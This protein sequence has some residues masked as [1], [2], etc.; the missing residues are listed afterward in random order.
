MFLRINHGTYFKRNSIMDYIIISEKDAIALKQ[1]KVNWH[2]GIDPVQLKSLEWVLNLEA[3]DL[4]PKKI[5]LSSLEKVVTTDLK[6]YLTDSVK[7]EVLLTDFK[8][9]PI[10]IKPI[11][12]IKR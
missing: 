1:F 5:A 3:I 9:E 4:I 8:V 7:R 6:T 12:I 10:E 11:E 2:S